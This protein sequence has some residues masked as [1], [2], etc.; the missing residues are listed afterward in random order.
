MTIASSR[1]P[2]PATRALRTLVQ[3]NKQRLGQSPTSSSR[4]ALDQSPPDEPL[5]LC[6]RGARMQ[7][8]RFLRRIPLD[9]Y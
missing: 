8:G 2:Y 9:G 1:S 6:G 4:A 3:S 7:G 5:L